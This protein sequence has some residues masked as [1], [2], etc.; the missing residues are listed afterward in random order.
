MNLTVAPIELSQLIWFLSQQFQAC[1]NLIKHGIPT[2]LSSVSN[3]N[4][5]HLT[6][7]QSST[8]SYIKMSFEEFKS[9]LEQHFEM[10]RQST[11]AGVTP[12]SSSEEQ[13]EHPKTLGRVWQLRNSSVLVRAPAPFS[14]GFGPPICP[15]LQG[16]GH[17]P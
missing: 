2:L 10:T 9:C 6:W 1:C 12:D 16:Q 3:F 5:V 17:K 4:E 8:F 14:K 11:Q 7:Q 13:E 15:S